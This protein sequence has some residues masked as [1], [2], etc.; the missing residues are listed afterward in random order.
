M[1]FRFQPMRDD[2]RVRRGCCQSARADC[3]DRPRG[4]DSHNGSDVAVSRAW[5]AIRR[6]SVA[7][8]DLF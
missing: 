5:Q 4:Q 7:E 1:R 6:R 8:G 3:F 2:N